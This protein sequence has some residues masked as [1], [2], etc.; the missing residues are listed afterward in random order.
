MVCCFKQK[1]AY[2]MRISDWS[3]DGCSSDLWNSADGSTT[4]PRRPAAPPGM[5]MTGR[6]RP[7]PLRGVIARQHA[8][9]PHLFDPRHRVSA[10]GQHCGNA[11]R[12]LHEIGRAHV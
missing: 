12:A 4:E 7:Y 5:T 6:A 8:R 2:E 11:F 9:L 1:T 3:S 10:L